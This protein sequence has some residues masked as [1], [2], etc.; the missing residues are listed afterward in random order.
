M[1]TILHLS[2]LHFGA[3]D[4][5]LM[6]PLIGVAAD[7]KPDLLVVSVD[8]TQR[9]RKSQFRKTRAFLDTMPYPQLVVPGNHDVPL[10]LPWKR[11]IK[12]FA[13][14]RRFI[15]QETEPVYINDEMAVIGVK[16][17]KS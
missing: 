1:R 2:D 14:Y 3:V 12:P 11:F 13:N 5:P 9:A 10:R 7:L 16:D 8:L 15:S 17:R 6:G 4:E